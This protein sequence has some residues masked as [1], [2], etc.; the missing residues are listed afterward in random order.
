MRK[1]AEKR[2]ESQPKMAAKKT[3]LAHQGVNVEGMRSISLI[4]SQMLICSACPLETVAHELVTVGRSEPTF[5][6]V[7]RDEEGLEYTTVEK[8]V[9]VATP[10]YMRARQTA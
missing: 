3:F 9:F 2:G 6:A 4:S 1:F 5:V 7:W 10:E 8:T